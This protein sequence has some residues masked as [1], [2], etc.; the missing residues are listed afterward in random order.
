M[1]AIDEIVLPLTAATALGWKP[2]HRTAHS[3]WRSW[4]RKNP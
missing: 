4:A 1:R 2:S 3:V